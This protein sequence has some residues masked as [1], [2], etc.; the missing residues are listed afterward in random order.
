MDINDM[1][2]RSNKWRVAILGAS[3]YAGAELLRL[4]AQHPN[5]SIAALTADRHAGKPIAQVFAQF[6]AR[7]LP[8]LVRIEDV[9][10]SVVDVAF[11]A[12]PHATTQEV[13][14]ALPRDLKVLDLSADF[15]FADV[16]VYAEWYG[17]AHLAPELQKDAVYGL[18]EMARE[19]IAAARLVAV[20][21]CYP[22]S[23]L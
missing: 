10:W 8:D 21:G 6:A 12:L 5:I 1:G 19:E 20:P 13:V 4:L 9:D 16:D 22:T 23:A 17:H 14:K 3:G 7:D 11:C 15:R 2:A 18:T